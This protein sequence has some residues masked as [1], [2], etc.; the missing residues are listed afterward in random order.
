MPCTYH[1]D[2]HRGVIFVG[3]WGVLTEPEI[4]S[5]GRAIRADPGMNARY[6]RLENLME[7]TEF[8][9]S[10]KFARAVARV[11]EKESPPRR[12]FVAGTDEVFGVLRMVEF[13]A[14][15]TEK[16]F[17]VCRGRCKPPRPRWS[18]LNHP[19]LPHSAGRTESTPGSHRSRGGSIEESIPPLKVEA[20]YPS[21]PRTAATWRL[22]R[23]PQFSFSV[24]PPHRSRRRRFRLPLDRW[25]RRPAW[26]GRMPAR[27]CMP[28]RCGTCEAAE[29]AGAAWEWEKEKGRRD[30]P[31]RWRNV[32]VFWPGLR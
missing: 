30:E 21:S 15:A 12:V 11:Q 22:P 16:G 32:A 20:F 13:F 24:V 9:V 28:T 8:R 14:D 7:V 26:C 6:T 25:N 23:L 19:D 1:I 29:P 27:L 5:A 3:A 18:R 10:T 4:V 17:L 2:T 31:V